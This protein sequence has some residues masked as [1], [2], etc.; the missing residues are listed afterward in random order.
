MIRLEGMIGGVRRLEG[1]SVIIR[2][3]GA[4]TRGVS[5]RLL[6]GRYEVMGE[7]VVVS[8]EIVEEWRYGGVSD[9]RLSN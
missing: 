1:G 3:L 7:K 6:Y 5:E 8:E 4:V 9:G 2:V